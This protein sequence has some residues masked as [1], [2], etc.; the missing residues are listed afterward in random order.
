MGIPPVTISISTSHTYM[1]TSPK[2]R[3]S[4]TVVRSFRITHTQDRLLNTP[5]HKEKIGPIVRVLLQL[6]F[7]KR[8]P[9]IDELIK[10]ETEAVDKIVKKN[11]ANFRE[12]L[13]NQGERK[14]PENG[15]NTS[16]I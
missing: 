6:Y 9:G 11:L 13:K 5:P 1:T 3:N 8:I 14:K 12:M 7:N 2:V 15:N 10:A 4:R 16:R